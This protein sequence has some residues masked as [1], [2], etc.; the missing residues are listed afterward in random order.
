MLKK[1]TSVIV[2]N[3]GIPPDFPCRDL[4]LSSVLGKVLSHLEEK[5]LKSIVLNACWKGTLNVIASVLNP[6]VLN[7]FSL[8]LPQVCNK[9]MLWINEVFQ[10]DPLEEAR[11]LYGDLENS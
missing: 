7:G 4:E 11:K 6:D 5:L 9:H 1:H 2:K 10:V 3:F 8:E